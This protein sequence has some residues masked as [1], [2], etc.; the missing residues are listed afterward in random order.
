M[1]KV[2][3]EKFAAQWEKYFDGAELPIAFYYTDKEEHAEM[4][5]VPEKSTGRSCVI[6]ELAQVRKGKPL[7][8]SGEQVG[9][10]G[11]KRYLGFAEGSAPNFEYFLSYGIP[12]KV[13]GERYKKSPEIVKEM[14]KYAPH[15]KAP[16][17][18]VVFKRWDMLEESDDPE[19]VF[20]FAKPD[21]LAGLFVLA[22]FD[23]AEPNGVFTPFCAG[24]GSVILYPYLE[25]SSERPRCVIGMFDITARPCV[26]ENTLTF[27]APMGKFSRMIENMEE[28]FLITHAWELV[29]KRISNS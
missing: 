19:V 2:I 11:G 28:S 15:F 13:E 10:S 22:N 17:K 24:C 8:Y 18:F 29:H 6:A 3:K 4:A 23:E 12:G 20:F 9:C 26:A 5:K 14:G 27:A 25:R 21:V 16:A 1:D 7:C